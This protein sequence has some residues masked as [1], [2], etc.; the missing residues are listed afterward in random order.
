MAYDFWTGCSAGSF[1]TLVNT[2]F[3]LAKTRLQ[4]MRGAASP[5]CLP[6]LL[7]INREEGF[8]ACFRGLAA[9]LYRAA[10]GSGI[11]LVGYETIKSWLTAP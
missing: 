1:A 11:L 6:F 8:R 10:P 7:G 9:R 5:W 3:D 2:P 4:C